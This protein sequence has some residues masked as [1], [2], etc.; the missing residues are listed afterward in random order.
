ME[1]AGRLHHGCL[2]DRSPC[3]QG[4]GEERDEGRQGGGTR[5]PQ[6]RFCGEAARSLNTALDVYFNPRDVLRSLKCCGSA[7]ANGRIHSPHTFDGWPTACGD[8]C[9][10]V[11]TR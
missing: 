3:Q 4:S 1:R 7:F 5:G 10:L 8:N 11:P 6:E 9:R 2:G